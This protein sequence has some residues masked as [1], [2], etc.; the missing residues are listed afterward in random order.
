MS[1]SWT[2]RS[3]RKSLASPSMPDP[4]TQ[5][6]ARNLTHIFITHAGWCWKL[7][8]QRWDC[9]LP[10]LPALP[11]ALPPSKSSC[12]KKTFAFGG[13][14]DQLETESQRLWRSG[15]QWLGSFLFNLLRVRFQGPYSEV[16]P[17]RDDSHGNFGSV[18]TKTAQNL[19]SQGRLFRIVPRLK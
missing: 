10:T 6:V 1:E 14:S 8:Y 4:E 19:K 2:I 18:I 7:R 5:N 13:V 9:R 17:I 16:P 12:M 11:T 15:Q 3:F